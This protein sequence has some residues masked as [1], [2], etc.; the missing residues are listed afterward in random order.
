MRTVLVGLLLCVA[1]LA[2]APIPGQSTGSAGAGTVTNVTCGSFGASWLTCSF[3][4]S[5][6]ATPVLT[7]GA[8]TGQT[9]H[10]VIGTCGTATSFGPCS[11]GTADLPSS[12]LLSGGPAGTPS[13]INLSNAVH[14][15]AAAIDPNTVA[16]NKL[17]TQAQDTLVMNE[18]SVAAPTAVALPTCTGASS[19]DVYDT[20]SHSWGCNSIPA[21]VTTNQNIR[22]IIADFGDFTSTASA[23]TASAQACGVAQMSGTIQRVVLFGTPSG[24]VTVDVRTVALASWTGPSSTSSIAA[25]DIPALVAQD[26]PYI[27]TTLTGWTTTVAA[28]TVFCFYLSSPTSITG[29]QIIL[30]LAAN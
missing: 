6:T 17:A 7:L 28:D 3:G 1:A 9:S 30:K 29:A 19:A 24:S 2:Q 23:L 22:S 4:G 14:L 27:D 25:A 21:A 11:L 13:S 8:A 20:S 18:A 5:T 15:A 12:V 16:L 26:T 10:Q